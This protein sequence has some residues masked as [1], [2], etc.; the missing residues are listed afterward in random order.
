V[1]GRKQDRVD[2]YAGMLRQLRLPAL[3]FEPQP[4]VEEQKAALGIDELIFHLAA[5]AGRDVSKK[6]IESEIDY[7][8]VQV[9]EELD[10]E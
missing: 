6:E 4:T 1:A 5:T 3:A 8:I 7:A 2:L 9:L 10:D